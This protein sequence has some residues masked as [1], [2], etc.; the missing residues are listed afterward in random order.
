MTNIAASQLNVCPVWSHHLHNTMYSVA[1]M[2]GHL[3]HWLSSASVL[4]LPK[5]LHHIHTCVHNDT[6]APHSSASWQNT[7]TSATPF[8]HKNHIALHISTPD[9]CFHQ[10]S[11]HETDGIVAC[12][13][14]AVRQVTQSTY[15]CSF[16][17]SMVS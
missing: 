17:K 8:T 13:L 15:S 1:D 3:G 5:A 16:M 14:M 7:S 11:H 6:H 12:P 4:L 9:H 2:S 10:V